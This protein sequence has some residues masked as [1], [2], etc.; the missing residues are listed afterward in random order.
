MLKLTVLDEFD[1][2][3]GD[4]PTDYLNTEKVVSKLLK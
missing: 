4:Y 1:I 2:N 3:N